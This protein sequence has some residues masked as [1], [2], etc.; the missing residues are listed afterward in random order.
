MQIG[1]G[2]QLLACLALCTTFLTACGPSEQRKAEM[3]E[4]KRIECVDKICEGDVAPK[5]ATTEDVIKLNGA[6]YIGP[7]KY[8][9]SGS[10]GGGFYWPSRHPM[11]AGGEYPEAQHDF[12]HK[13]IEIFLTGR[14]RW[15]D[16]KIVAPWE[17]ASWEKRFVALQGEGMFTLTSASMP[18]TLTTGPK[19][20]SKSSACCNSSGR[21]DQG[22]VGTAEL[23]LL[24]A[25]AVRFGPVAVAQHPHAPVGFAAIA[26]PS[27]GVIETANRSAA[28]IFHFPSFHCCRLSRMFMKKHNVEAKRLRQASV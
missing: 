5:R 26:S 21:H 6:W 8:F 22:A 24:T 28:K 23:A 18:N 13:A 11:F 9:S 2:M 14:Q 20:I 10:N 17:N 27:T 7:Q 3:A 19:Y 15:P 16:P 4:K 12:Y 1:I 25:L